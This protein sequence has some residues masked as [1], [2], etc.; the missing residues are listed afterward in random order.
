MERAF[1]EPTKAI[2]L[3]VPDDVRPARAGPTLSCCR[4]RSLRIR[5]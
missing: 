5:R 3:N 4:A 1:L 2:L